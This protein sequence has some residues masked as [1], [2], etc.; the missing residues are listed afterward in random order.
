LFGY[1]V[2]PCVYLCTTISSVEEQFW[3]QVAA[4]LWLVCTAISSVEEQFWSQVAAVLW[5]VCTAISSVEEQWEIWKGYDWIVR[6]V[7]FGA[8][9][10]LHCNL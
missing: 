10:G 8:V 4:V 1:Q 3:S 7:V 6:L 9:V 2:S 5:L